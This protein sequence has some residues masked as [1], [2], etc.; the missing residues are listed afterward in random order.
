MSA[1]LRSQRVRFLIILV[2]F[3]TLSRILIDYI[4]DL[5][6][7]ALELFTFIQF[8][9]VLFHDFSTVF[10]TLPGFRQVGV[11]RVYDWS[12]VSMS[13]LTG[14]G[15]VGGL[16]RTVLLD[17]TLRFEFVVCRWHLLSEAPRHRDSCLKVSSGCARLP[18]NARVPFH[19][20]TND[21]SRALGM[22]R[23]L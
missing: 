12:L 3:L 5:I 1:R 20:V 21:C 7:L 2:S 17:R 14:K 13:H 23:K 4:L 11:M 22:G 10:G 18:A 15:S 9:V 19:V 6:R 8:R 16:L